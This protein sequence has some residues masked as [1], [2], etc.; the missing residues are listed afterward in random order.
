MTTDDMLNKMLGKTKKKTN[1]NVG[2]SNLFPN[3]TKAVQRHPLVKDLKRGYNKASKPL[4]KMCDPNK[5]LGKDVSRNKEQKVWTCYDKLPDG[6]ECGHQVITES[7]EEPLP[8]KWKDG[9]VCNFK[10]Y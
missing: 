10:N 7:N 8:V 9:H 4:F 3:T 5:I 2:L 1:S 6:S